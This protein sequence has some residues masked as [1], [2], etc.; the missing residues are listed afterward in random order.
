[1]KSETGSADV[2]Y[3][4]ILVKLSGESLAGEEKF[5]IDPGVVARIAAEVAGV[6]RLGVQVA[7]VIGG[8]NIFRGSTGKALGM[9]RATGDYMGMLAT[10]INSL[11]MQD[12]LEKQGVPTRVMTSMEM[13]AVAEPYIRRRAIRHLERGHV[14][15]LSG[16]MGNPFFTTDTA[17]GLRAIE[18][19]AELLMKGTRVDGVYDSDPEKNP[20]ARRISAISYL[21]VVERKLRIM[22]LTA[23]TLCMDNSMPVVV[24]NLFQENAI[25]RIVAGEHVGTTIS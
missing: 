14:V 3:H 16:G 10:V 2:R 1:M 6:F 12:A 23:I 4:R 22:D 17:A 24:F 21:E 15:I 8:G 13:R 7:M 11:A 5:G 19:G 20:D 18:I 25:A 9:E